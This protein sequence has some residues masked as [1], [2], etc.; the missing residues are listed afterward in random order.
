MVEWS[1]DHKA[2]ELQPSV[3]SDVAR[4]PST[5]SPC[6]EVTQGEGPTFEQGDK[7]PPFLLELF[8]GTAGVCAQF[9]TLGGRALGIDHHLKRTKLKAAAVK[10][11]LTQM[12]VQELIEREIKLKRVAAVHM[13]PPCG[14]SSKARNIPIKRKL[15]AQGAPNPQP[16]RSSKFPL[17]FP[18]L[19]GLNKVKVQAANQLY[20][21]AAK[22][23]TLCNDCDVL[24][25]I[26]NPANSF[27][28]DSVLQTFVGKVQLSCPR[29]V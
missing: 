23:A 5:F 22:V 21:F 2:T 25:T 13:G 4:A 14:T 10:L 7:L 28:G 16:L 26:E 3:R 24:V 29:C 6:A 17:G 11:D 1:Q 15:R 19:K 18:W 20:E 9:R 8:C 27:M 12:W